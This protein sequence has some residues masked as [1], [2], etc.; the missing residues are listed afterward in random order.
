MRPAMYGMWLS[1]IGTAFLASRAAA[2]GTKKSD[3]KEP[4]PRP[5]TRRALNVVRQGLP[6]AKCDPGDLTKSDTAWEIEWEITSPDNGTGKKDS[7]PS[8]VLAIRSAKFMFKDHAK[9]VRWFTVLKNLE[10]G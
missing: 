10:V 8:S 9:T 1:M 7:R 5:T 3:N 4:E 6:A 2:Q